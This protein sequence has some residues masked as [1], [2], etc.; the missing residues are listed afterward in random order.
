MRA[1][2]SERYLNWLEGQHTR[3][4]RSGNDGV[5]K[6]HPP[7]R[8][9][10]IG[11]VE[12]GRF[13]PGNEKASDFGTL[14]LNT[15]VHKAEHASKIGPDKVW[16]SGARII[17]KRDVV[18]VSNMVE[19]AEHLDPGTNLW[20]EMCEWAQARIVEMEAENEGG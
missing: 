10:W 1:Y 20:A 12:P 17:P 18:A 16:G 3:C 13:S 19:Y 14:M 6:A 4:Q 15:T 7:R 5:E 9:P 11:E 8:R 2:R